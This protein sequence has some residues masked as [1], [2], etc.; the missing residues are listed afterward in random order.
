LQ[1][2]AFLE[3]ALGGVKYLR[4]LRSTPWGFGGAML[5]FLVLF[6]VLNFDFLRPMFSEPK[7]SRFLWMVHSWFP[8]R[9]SVTFIHNLTKFIKHIIIYYIL[10]SNKGIFVWPIWPEVNS[11]FSHPG[12]ITGYWITTRSFPYRG[13]YCPRPIWASTSSQ[14]NMG[15]SFL[16]VGSM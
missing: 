10:S 14:A 8:R 3:K 15:V 4:A 16:D 2:P 9:Y 12:K 13:P 7:W 11:I 5:L 1:S 6:L